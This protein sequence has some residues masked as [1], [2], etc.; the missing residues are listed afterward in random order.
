MPDIRDRVEEERGLLKRIQLHVPGFAG[1]RRREDIR[2]ADN[3]LRRQLAD[4]IEDARRRVEAAREVLAENYQMAV[5]DDVGGLIHSIQSLEGKVR[6]AEGGYS[7]ISATMRILEDELNYLYEYDLSMLSA[8]ELMGQEADALRRSAGGDDVS[9]KIAKLISLVN[10][11]EATFE[12]RM[13]T[14]TKTEVSK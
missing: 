6:H 14:I 1:Y 5:L 9:E 8:V 7:G 3:M 2:T 12:K 10:D 13:R 4:M 11:F